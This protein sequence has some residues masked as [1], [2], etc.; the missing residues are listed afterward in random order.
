VADHLDNNDRID[1]SVAHPAR[2]YNYLLG[3][4]DNFEADRRSAEEIVARHPTA[5][6]SAQENRLFLHRAAGYMARQGIRQFLD[7][8]TGIPVSPNTHEIAQRIDPAARV[9]YVDNDPLVLSHARALLTT[10]PRGK[11]AYIEADLRRPREILDDLQ[12]RDTLDLSQPVGL[13]LIA[14]LHFIRDD[15]DPAAII[16]ALVGALAPGSLVVATHAT[17]EHMPAEQVAALRSTMETQWADR[18]GPALTALFDRPD[19][20]LVAPGVQSIT[21]WW[22]EDAPQPRPP[23]ED[24]ACNGLVAR[25][26][27]G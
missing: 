1:A 18:P 22:A 5:R 27:R 4:K 15:D 6:L 16:A 17:P 11:T 2:R 24:V 26:V 8:G 21:R 25:V 20:R 7:I 9:V 14:V 13:L 12:L 3:G 23:V 19:L 10:D